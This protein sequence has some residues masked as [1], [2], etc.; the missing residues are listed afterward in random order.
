MVIIF[1]ACK[2][3][4]KDNRYTTLVLEEDGTEIPSSS[5]MILSNDKTFMV[6]SK[7]EKWKPSFNDKSDVIKYVNGRLVKVYGVLYTIPEQS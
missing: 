7:E 5:A 3:F 2:M 4:D 1:L 6:L